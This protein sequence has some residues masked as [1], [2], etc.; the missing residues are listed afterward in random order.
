M[1]QLEVYISLPLAMCLIMNL[2]DDTENYTHRSGRTARAG[3]KGESLVLVTPKEGYKIKAI[4]RKIR[5]TFT[6]GTIPG[7]KEICEIQL[8]KLNRHFLP[9]LKK[10]ISLNSFLLLWLILKIYRKKR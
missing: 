8:K 9:K 2:P 4:E 10:H 6:K 5:T 7:A 1:L 3:K